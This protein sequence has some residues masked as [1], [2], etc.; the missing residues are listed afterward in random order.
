MT[1]LSSDTD[2]ALGLLDWADKYLAEHFSLKPSKMHEWLANRLDKLR[3]QRGGRINLIGPRGSAKST[4]ATLAYV[5]RAAASAWEPYIWIISDTAEQ[6][7]CHLENVKVELVE[8]DL[9]RHTYGICPGRVWRRT[10][11]LL[12]NGVTIECFGTGQRI[13]GRRRR[14]DRP[15]LI[16]CDDL[17]N[18]RHMDSVRQRESSRRWFHGTLM[19]AGTPQTNVVHL[20]TALHIDALALELSRTPGWL[21]GL[22]RSIEQW[23][24]NMPL[25]GEW[26]R[27]LSNLENPD[28]DEL[29]RAFYK[30]RQEEMD[31]GADVLWP[32]R[33]GL[34][35]LMM[36]RLR[37]GHPAFE[38]EKQS[39]PID[40]ERC[41]WPA[42]YFEGEL[43][44]E[45][46][47]SEYMVRT[48]A[49]DP[50]KGTDARRGDYSAFV[51][52]SVAAGTGLLFIEANLARR[53]GAQIVADGV[54]LIR[55]FHPQRFVIETNQFQSLFADNFLDELKRAGIHDVVPM[56]EEN[57]LSKLVRIRSLGPHLARHRFR[58]KRDSPSTKLLVDQLRQ[59]PIGDHD[60]GPD[61]LEMAL[62]AAGQMLA[63]SADDG[64]GDRLPISAP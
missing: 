63:K 64:L 3:T 55:Q 20:A 28:V 29:A 44:F 38:R 39:S 8:N 13:R 52:L 59:F 7:Q 9:V 2:E 16:I 47:P 62:R 23:P 46:W 24:I 27:I 61:A 43:W 49:L 1:L 57:K 60:D 45:N 48:I 26:E 4:V 19:Q 30:A 11:L 53:D 25:W 14:A 54:E 5:L 21:T 51:M 10:V 56:G 33:E 58:F 32:E 35:E 12:T 41:E 42:Q 36:Q 50:S 17:Q 18:D 22:F 31:L 15:S 6:A 37:S 34:Y 40:P